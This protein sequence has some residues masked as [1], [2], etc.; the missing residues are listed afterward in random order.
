[1]DMSEFGSLDELGSE[2][3]FLGVQP[4]I[5]DWDQEILGDSEAPTLASPMG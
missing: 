4:T 2:M 3:M 1:M 5:W